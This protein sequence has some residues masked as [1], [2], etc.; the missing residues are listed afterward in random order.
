MQ[1]KLRIIMKPYIRNF[2]SGSFKS[3]SFK[4]LELED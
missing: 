4:C 3:I 2:Y 1:I